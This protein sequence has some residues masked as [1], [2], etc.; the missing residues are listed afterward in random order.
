[1]IEQLIENLFKPA[2]VMKIKKATT[3]REK[4]VK[5]L[6]ESAIDFPR[7]GLDPQ[8][9]QKAENGWALKEEVKHVIYET[10]AQYQAEDLKQ[11]AEKI[12]IVGSICS[13][14]YQDD[15]DIDVH[16]VP[17]NAKD[18]PEERVQEVKKFFLEDPKLIGAHPIEVYI[19]V[20]AEQDLMSIGAYDIINDVWD[21]GPTLMP[22]SFNPYKF[23]H[24]LADE[25]ESRVERA[26][27]IIA[28]LKRD[29]IDYD[30]ILTAMKHMDHSS[31]QKLH[32]LLQ[33]KAEEIENSIQ[34]LYAE[35]KKWA[36]ARKHSS[37]G[38]TEPD[39]EW[40]DENATFK[41]LD[42]YQYIKLAG[43]LYDLIEDDDVDQD[44]VKQIAGK[45]GIQSE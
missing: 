22:A 5:M 7:Q 44:D 8:I 9:W 35:R 26:D 42:R 43:Y 2:A 36:D 11:I 21:A 23:Y 33:S 18:W 40:K 1:M 20:N 30:E 34:E 29:T 6:Q 14:Q 39:K 32:A 16:I 25:V 41:F 17:T 24:H 37:T 19:Q 4:I 10:L 27:E 28:A 15:S 45:L 38:K 3:V 31:K 13:N 12:R